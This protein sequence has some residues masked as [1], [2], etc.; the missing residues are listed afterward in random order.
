MGFASSYNILHDCKHRFINENRDKN[1]RACLNEKRLCDDGFYFK[2]LSISLEINKI[3]PFPA[4][5]MANLKGL[6][7]NPELK[8]CLS[9]YFVKK[10]T[11][12]INQVS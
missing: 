10:W 8:P 1:E 2:Y 9:A 11:G 7:G 5:P 4:P 6:K 3:L 12:N